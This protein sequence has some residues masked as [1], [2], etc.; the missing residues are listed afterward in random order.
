MK[1]VEFLKDHREHKV[2]DIVEVANNDCFY[3]EQEG[4]AVWLDRPEI[5]E[6]KVVEKA[7]KKVVKKVVNKVAKKVVKKTVRK[8]KTKEMTAGKKKGYKTK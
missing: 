6:V 8:R 7:V 3:L 4:V 1:R 2:G 5:K